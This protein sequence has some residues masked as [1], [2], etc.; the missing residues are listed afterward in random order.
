[1]AAA[2]KLG[3]I[4]GSGLYD[5]PGLTHMQWQDVETPWGKPSDDL[6]TGKL[7]KT[8]MVFLPRH[9]RGHFISP[10]N[11]NARANIAAMK[12]LGVTDILSISA[13]GSFNEQ[14]P[15]GTF[16]LVDQFMD[17]T[18]NRV[19]SYFTESVVAHVS[20]AD[21]TCGRLRDAAQCA[22]TRCGISHLPRGTYVCIEGPQFSTRAESRLYKSW[23]ADVI[24]MTNLPEAALA[25]EAEIC[26][27]T[28][29]MVTDF[30]SWISEESHVDLPELIATL[31]ANVDKAKLL[32]TE[33]AN[34]LQPTRGTCAKGCDMALEH[35]IMT[36]PE[37]RHATDVAKLKPIAGRVL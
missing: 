16:V 15:P 17:R 3:I 10:T 13:V 35:A 9:G 24:G 1:M 22:A 32:V 14:A 20:L 34:H 37:K 28:V 6:L 7:G 33:I 4:G 8:E 25:R 21:P 18:Q 30:D 11:L 5:L 19:K 27:L 2:V 12:Q 36:A 31:Q 29:A 26:Y 23:G